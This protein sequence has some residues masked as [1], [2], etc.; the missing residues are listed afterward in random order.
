MTTEALE[1][2]LLQKTPSGDSSLRLQLFTADQGIV[3][4]TY[5]GGRTPAKQAV[6]QAFTPLWLSLEQRRDW[7]YARRIES[8]AM[9]LTLSGH[10]L[11]AALYLNEIIHYALKPLDPCPDV[12]HA[13]QYALHGLSLACDKPTLESLLR[14]FEWVLLH[15]GGHGLA[16][17]DVGADYYRF[18]AGCGFVAANEGLPAAVV[19]G[20][21]RGEFDTVAVLQAARRVMR[22]AIDYLLAGQELTSRR[23][24][25]GVRT[26][27]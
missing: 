16:F 19:S 7:H 11:F 6:L 5:K 24:F 12:Y 15:H 3:T 10:N 2:W 1:A 14:R 9:P 21:I 4:C 17:V 20:M 18:I 13:Y 8:R 26:S 27:L 25:A 23:L 22:S